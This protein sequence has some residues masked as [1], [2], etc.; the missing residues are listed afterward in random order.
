MRQELCYQS[1]CKFPSQ[2][3]IS[4]LYPGIYVFLFANFSCDS[5]RP[6]IFGSVDPPC[7]HMHVHI[8]NFWEMESKWLLSF[9]SFRKFDL[10]DLF[11]NKH[12]H[13]LEPDISWVLLEYI[14]TL[15]SEMIQWTWASHHLS[16]VVRIRNTWSFLGIQVDDRCRRIRLHEGGKVMLI[17]KHDFIR[18]RNS[19][20][21]KCKSANS[22]TSP[23]VTRWSLACLAQADGTVITICKGDTNSG[24]QLSHSP[25]CV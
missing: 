25:C 24:P 4:G 22:P 3:Q 20:H 15:K 13:I 16:E 9:S 6:D 23:L 17:S 2:G 19:Q 11:V 12:W 10:V 14:L 1:G 8:R 21:L 18:R 5:E 7:V